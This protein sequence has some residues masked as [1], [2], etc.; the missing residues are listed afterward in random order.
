M[1]EKLVGEGFSTCLEHELF[2]IK[3]PAAI[4]TGVS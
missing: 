1:E 2:K 4:Q 3:T